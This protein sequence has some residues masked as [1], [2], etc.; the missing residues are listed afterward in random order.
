MDLALAA[1]ENSIDIPLVLKLRIL[2]INFFVWYSLQYYD[3]DTATTA[4]SQPTC[5]FVVRAQGSQ[6][7]GLVMARE[8]NIPMFGMKNTP[9]F[10]I[11]KC[12][13]AGLHCCKQNKVTPLVFWS[14][15]QSLLNN[16]YFAFTTSSKYSFS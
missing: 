16:A 7:H 4:F 8:K 14:R 10:G 1:S 9:M 3:S 11:S 15:R 2:E 13:R 12:Y 5:W 6:E